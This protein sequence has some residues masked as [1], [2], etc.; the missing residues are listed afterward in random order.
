MHL[1]NLDALSNLAQQRDG[2]LAAQVFLEF[3]QPFDQPDLMQI[4]RVP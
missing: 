4:A 1:V 3:R 2:H